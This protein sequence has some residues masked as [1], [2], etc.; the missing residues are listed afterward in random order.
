MRTKHTLLL[1]LALLFAAGLLATC[2][3]NSENKGRLLYQSDFSK[4]LGAEWKNEG[5]DW[6]VENGTL[7]SRDAKNK[8]LVLLKPLP[9]EATIELEVISH[10]PQVDIKFRAWGDAAKN[11][12]DGAY[13][14]IL[15]GWNN[16]ISTIAPLGEHDPRRVERR[17]ALKSEHWYTLRLQRQKGRFELFVD[18][19][20]F[21]SYDDR[22]P[23][24]PQV[25]KFFSFANWKTDCEFKNLKIYSAE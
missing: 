5:G 7:R 4:P 23:L 10:S 24:D 1:G 19:Q 11:L 13:H 22:E 18:G 2:S 14:F 17:E 9:K 25:F 16:T 12:H 15:A 6:T 21:L 3:G 20:K 8:D